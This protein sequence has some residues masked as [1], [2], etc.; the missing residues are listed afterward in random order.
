MNSLLE[1]KK[2]KDIKNINKI[3]IFLENFME[4]CDTELYEYGSGKNQEHEKQILYFLNIKTIIVEKII[5]FF[6]NCKDKIIKILKEKEKKHKDILTQIQS[7]IKDLST[8]IERNKEARNEYKIYQDW[9]I[10]Q[11]YS[12]DSHLSKLKSYF[13]AYINQKLNLEM[14]YTFD[15]QFCLWAIKKEFAKYFD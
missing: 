9:R 8:F 5:Q 4:N 10:E 12:K 1:N 14:N 7:N 2:E 3:K 6:E 11:N 15:S 13:R